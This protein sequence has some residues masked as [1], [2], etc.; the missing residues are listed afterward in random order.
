[1][2]T[3]TCGITDV[4]PIRKLNSKIDR[5][6]VDMAIPTKEKMMKKKS[7]KIIFFLL[8]ISPK[9]TISNRPKAYP[10]CVNMAELL[11]IAS[12]ICRSLAIKPNSG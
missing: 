12:S 10:I 5:I 4:K 11:T 2:G 3:K 6:E 9:G 7:I 8:N 1:M